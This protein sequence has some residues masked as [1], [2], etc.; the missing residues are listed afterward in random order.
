MGPNLLF[1]HLGAR[2]QSLL[3][4]VSPQ[5]HVPTDHWGQG[6]LLNQVPFSFFGNPTFFSQEPASVS[7]SAIISLL[8]VLVNICFFFFLTIHFIPFIH[9]NFLESRA[10]ALLPS[11]HFHC[12]DGQWVVSKDIHPI[13]E[14]ENVDF[15]NRNDVCWV[16]LMPLKWEKFLQPFLRLHPIEICLL[17]NSN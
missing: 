8:W 5:S 12:K 4:C 14:L 10:C 13:M 3:V 9:C 16:F 15:R 17:N 11:V 2:H 1:W 7:P 6:P